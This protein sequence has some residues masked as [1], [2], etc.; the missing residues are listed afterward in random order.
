MFSLSG[1]VEN[2]RRYLL[3]RTDILQKT[4]DGCPCI[5]SEDDCH[6]RIRSTTFCSHFAPH[7]T[8][9][10]R[11][12]AMNELKNDFTLFSRDYKLAKSAVEMYN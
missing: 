9:S 6:F 12:D 4:V 2:F 10:L 8:H 11:Y 5:V 3:I 1:A 7:D